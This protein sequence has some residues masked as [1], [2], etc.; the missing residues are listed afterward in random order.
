MEKTNNTTE[1]K[2]HPTIN[3]RLLLL[4]KRMNTHKELINRL[5]GLVEKQVPMTLDFI[6]VWEKEK[7]ALIEKQQELL[8]KVEAQE[9][10]IAA[11]EVIMEKM[12]GIIE[13]LAPEFLESDK[14][15]RKERA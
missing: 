3:D 2:E 13:V 8:K 11:H 4:N 15:S 5:L 9:V 12:T 14:G 1:T 10:R 7:T 6:E